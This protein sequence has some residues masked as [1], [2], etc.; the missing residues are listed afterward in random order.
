MALLTQTSIGPKRSS[1][2]A[3]AAST[4]FGVG[5]VGRQHQRLAAERFDFGAS[6]FQAL[7]AA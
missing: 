4:A 7:A 6:L 5:D 3:A 2:A 1:T